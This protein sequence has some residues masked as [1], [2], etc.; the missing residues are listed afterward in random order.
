[1][2]RPHF[3]RKERERLFELR[4]GHCYL[5][6]GD[7]TPALEAWDVEHEI[8]WEISYDNSDGNLRLAHVKCHKV[9][10]AKD[11]KDIAKVHRIAA[12]HNG[13]APPSRA[14]IQS[15]GFPKSRVWQPSGNENS[16]DNTD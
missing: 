1:M 10:T 8:P 6:R 15:R 4:K 2:T 13:T 5:C 7:I 14:K 12:K 9:K 16:H 11:R 3:S